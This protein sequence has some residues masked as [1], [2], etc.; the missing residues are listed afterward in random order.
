MD[1]FRDSARP[2]KGRRK[3]ANDDA[4]RAAAPADAGARGG[5]HERAQQRL[6]RL[7]WL[8]DSSVRIPSTRLRFGVDGVVGLVPV[9]GDLAS[10]AL[11][12][13]PVFEA[14]R[15]GLRAP[16][17]LLMLGNVAVDAAV[18]A[19]PVLGDL[20]DFGFKA[21]QRNVDLVRR[22]LRERRGQGDE[23]ACADDAP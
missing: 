19:I 22:R 5:A 13:Y 6:D 16:T 3:R 10:A 1:H 17:I 11:A 15:L 2:R 14:R 4:A 9:V 18:G 12:L 7:A 8:L 23:A 21:N 20:F